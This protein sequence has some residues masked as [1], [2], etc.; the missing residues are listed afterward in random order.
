MTMTAKVLK[1]QFAAVFSEL[2]ARPRRLRAVVRG[3][4]GFAID[5]DCGEAII[6][7]PTGERVRAGFRHR[8]LAEHETPFVL[9]VKNI[10]EMIPTT[11]NRVKVRIK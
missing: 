7:S 2:D 5:F 1:D 4:E 6:V 3:A 8:Y 9:G 11:G 10:F